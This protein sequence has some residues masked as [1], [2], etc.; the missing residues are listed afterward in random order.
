MSDLEVKA[1]TDR[2]A[3]SRDRLR[4]RL[5]VGQSGGPAVVINSALVGVIHEALGYPEIEAIYG[6]RHGILGALRE[7]FC[8]L[9][10]EDAA[11]IEGLRYTPSAALGTGRYRLTPTDYD[12]VLQVFRAHNIRYFCYVGGSDS[13]GTARRIDMLARDV[14]YELRVVGVPK[15]VD[16]DLTHT[17]HCP[18][19]GSAARFVALMLRD[20]GLDTITA[21][22]STPVRIV[23]IMGR[24]VGWLAAAAALARE[25]REEAPPDLIYV[26]ERP[27]SIDRFLADVRQVY[28]E[29]GYC[30]VALSEGVRDEHGNLVASLIGDSDAF[31]HQQLG[32]ASAYLGQLVDSELGLGCRFE[33]SHTMQCSMM[34][35]ASPVDLGEAYTV[36]RMAVHKMTKGVSGKMVSLIRAPG[37]AY[38]CVTGL[39]DLELVTEAERP[40]SA[41]YLDERGHPTAAFVDYALPLIG[42]PLPPYRHLL[43]YAVP[44]RL[45]D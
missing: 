16:N 13:M 27:F 44:R 28:Q 42:A 10:R 29:R 1:R 3:L 45:G 8:D 11:T 33:R 25:G 4:G 38:Y 6:M 12:R 34:L 35:C 43:G 17:D 32:G 15:T 19:Y 40:L 20:A 37:P 22:L 31:G 18:G 26:P 30:V 36:G 2:A 24:R 14:G 9:G 21:A 23:E 7:D 5:L 41:E 39:V